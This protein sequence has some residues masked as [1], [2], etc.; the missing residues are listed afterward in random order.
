[1]LY[2][3]HRRDTHPWWYQTFAPAIGASRIA[4]IDV[5]RNNLLTARHVTSELYHGDIRQSDV[6][7]GFGLVFWDEGP[8]HLPREES[9]ELCRYLA[10]RNARVLI[11]CPW[12]FQEQGEDRNDPEFHHWGPVPEDFASIGWQ[13]RTFGVKFPDGHGNLIAWK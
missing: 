3:G 4:V 8:E 11:S 10:R 2:V 9:L 13:T 5:D 7:H 6:P 12:G 1:M